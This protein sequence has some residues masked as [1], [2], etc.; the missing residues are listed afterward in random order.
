MLRLGLGLDVGGL[1]LGLDARGLGLNAR[2]LGLGLHGGGWQLRLDGTSHA[3]VVA[4]D[5][6]DVF[7][8]LLLAALLYPLLLQHL[9][10][11]GVVEFSSYWR[12]LFIAS[13]GV[14]E[15]GEQQS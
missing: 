6:H 1:G 4:R 13:G 15:E 8:F 9:P 10:R 12:R 11:C 7:R 14:L 5:V 3:A 2:G